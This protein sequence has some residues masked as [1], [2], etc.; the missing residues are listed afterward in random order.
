MLNKTWSSVS[1][2]NLTKTFVLGSLESLK[3]WSSVLSLQRSFSL[4]LILGQNKIWVWKNIWVWKY[5]GFEKNFG[6]IQNFYLKNI[7]GLKNFKSKKCFGWKKYLVQKQFWVQKNFLSEFF[8]W[9]LV[10]LVTW[11]I[12]TPYPLNSA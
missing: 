10:L 3:F 8:F 7:L 6:S 9:V 12:Q 2:S 4:K 11:V 5:F 1:N